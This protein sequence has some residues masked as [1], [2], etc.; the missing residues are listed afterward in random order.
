[1][2]IASKIDKKLARKSH[3]DNIIEEDVDSEVK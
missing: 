1:M 3:E 2:K